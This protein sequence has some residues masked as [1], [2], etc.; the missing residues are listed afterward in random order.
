[1]L[2]HGRSVPGLAVRLGAGQL[3]TYHR[4]E[5]KLLKSKQINEA[6]TQGRRVEEGSLSLQI[7][8]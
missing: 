4:G 3:R 1:M 5:L 7:T 2:L 8:A 6:Q